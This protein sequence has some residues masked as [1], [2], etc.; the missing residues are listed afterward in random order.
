MS[1][2]TAHFNPTMP[3]NP[4]TGS[5]RYPADP[6]QGINKGFLSESFLKVYNETRGVV[7]SVI[8]LIST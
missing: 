4:N 8:A 6:L 7:S 5:G 3:M 2:V 1:S